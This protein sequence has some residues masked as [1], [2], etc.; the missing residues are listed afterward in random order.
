MVQQAPSTSRLAPCVLQNTTTNLQSVTGKMQPT[1]HKMQQRPCK[2]QTAPR[3]MQRTP[4][5]LLMTPRILQITP[6]KLQKPSNK[7]QI[8]PDNLQIASSYLQITPNKLQIP[9]NNMQHRSVNLRISTNNLR[10]TGIQKITPRPK[11]KQATAQWQ[12][13]L[14]FA[15]SPRLFLKLQKSLPFSRPQ[16]ISTANRIL[17]IRTIFVRI[18]RIIETIQ[19]NMIDNQTQLL[20]APIHNAGFVGLKQHPA[21]IK[22]QVGETDSSFNSAL[23]IAAGRY[24]Q[25]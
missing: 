10:M 6:C 16:I 15:Q 2:V 21:F 12:A 4:R 23:C 9:T 22:F 13:H 3:N 18:T 1:P 20:T 19:T 8:R 24:P 11:A 14:Q 25:F 5:F 7:L 17:R